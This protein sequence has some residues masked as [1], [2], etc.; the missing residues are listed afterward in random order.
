MY[1]FS[2]AV[3]NGFAQAFDFQS[4]AARSEYWFWVLFVVLANLAARMVDAGLYGMVNGPVTAVVVLALLIPGL[5]Y[6]VR[7][8]HDLG[9]TGW[10]VLLLLVPIIGPIAVVVWFIQPGE[11]GPNDYGPDPLAAGPDGA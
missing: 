9:R 3:S 1:S 7:R 4:R 2:Q 10:W 5:A 8:F 11:S 6:A